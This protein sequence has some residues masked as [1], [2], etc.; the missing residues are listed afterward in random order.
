[1]RKEVLA[2][3]L[4][5]LGLGFVGYRFVDWEQLFSVLSQAKLGP[6]VL[7]GLFFLLGMVLYAWRWQVLIPADI[8]LT[9]MFHA[10]NIGHAGNLII[11]GRAGEPIRVG[12]VAD[13]CDASLGEVTGT[14]VVEKVMEQFMRLGC[15]VLALPF[16]GAKAGMDRIGPLVVSLIVLM[17]LVVLFI[18]FHVAIS[19]QVS[20]LVERVFKI[21]RART[22]AQFK[23]LVHLLVNLRGDPKLVKSVGISVLC[24][25]AFAVHSWF[26]LLALGAERLILG[27]LI[28]MASVTPSAPTHPGWYHAIGVASLAVVGF[29]AQEALA[30]LVLLHAYQTVLY[31]LLGLVGYWLLGSPGLRNRS[32][33]AES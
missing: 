1:M 4:A 22:Q 25:A 9:K 18:R 17:A 11:P 21:P 29:G 33:P 13:Q 23:D 10:S 14:V 15:V 5:V 8:S 12:V 20:I 30:W 19:L 24:W 31:P 16:L 7:S 6:S 26:G 28:V 2:T 3:I 32:Q 27:S